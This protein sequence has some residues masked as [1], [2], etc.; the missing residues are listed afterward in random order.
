MT[1]SKLGVTSGGIL[2]S[3]LG[4]TFLSCG[5]PTTRAIQR[6]LPSHPGNIFLTGERVVVTAPYGEA[7][8]WHAVDYDG[9]TV[10]EG[11]V[12]NGQAALGQLSAGYYELLRGTANSTNRISVGVLEPLRAPTPLTSPIDIDVAMAWFFPK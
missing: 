6:T 4:L 1:G 2:L 7:D 3:F 9:K 10:A 8:T 12:E 11:R 5:A